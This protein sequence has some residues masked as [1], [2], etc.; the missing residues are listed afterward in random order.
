MARSGRDPTAGLS[1]R[2]RDAL[3]RQRK[4]R[5]IAARHLMNEI[6]RGLALAEHG[7]RTRAL[8]RRE[9]Y[10]RQARDTY[11]QLELSLSKFEL[12]PRQFALIRLHL[13]RLGARIQAAE[14]SS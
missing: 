14:Q 10:L 9:E 11:L 7:M 6:E 1:D 2:I 12:K 5:R 3:R 13:E 8:G 4:A